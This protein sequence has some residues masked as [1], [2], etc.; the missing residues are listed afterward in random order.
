MRPSSCKKL[1]WTTWNR[2]LRQMLHWWWVY[3]RLTV[4][5]VTLNSFRY[6]LNLLIQF[7]DLFNLVWNVTANSKHRIA[8][9]KVVNPKFMVTSA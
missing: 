2:M 9:I 7:N 3:I 8:S 4:Q 1:Y 6:V 5:V